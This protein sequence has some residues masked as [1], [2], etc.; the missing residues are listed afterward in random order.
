MPDVEATKSCPK[1]AYDDPTM[2]R[3]R[4]IWTDNKD[5][6]TDTHEHQVEYPA[7]STH[8]QT[9]SGCTECQEYSM[10]I[11][12]SYD[13]SVLFFDLDNNQTGL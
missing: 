4:D 2:S 1:G 11:K 9:H 5:I 6:W 3:N 13:W 10:R 7:I 12:N 8:T